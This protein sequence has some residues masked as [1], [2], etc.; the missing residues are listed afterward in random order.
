VLVEIT[1]L[2]GKGIILNNYTYLELNRDLEINS[3]K[4]QNGFYIIKFTVGE[5]VFISRIVKQ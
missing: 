4:L 5:E 1:D 3:S 2:N